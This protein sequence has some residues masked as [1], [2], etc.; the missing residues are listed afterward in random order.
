[1]KVW[2]Y[3]IILLLCG[4]FVTAAAPGWVERLGK[5]E[6]WTVNTS[7]SMEIRQEGDAICFAA[8]NPKGDDFWFYPV[9]TLRPEE[10]A[11]GLVEFS[12]DA[13]TDR[14]ENVKYSFIMAGGKYHKYP[15]P[16]SEWRRVT[17][18]IPAADRKNIRDIKI[19]MNA[20]DAEP[21]KLWV[22]NFSATFVPNVPVADLPA[23][24]ESLALKAAVPSAVFYD[25]EPL[26]FELE[27]RFRKPCRYQV[28][29]WR[30]QEIQAGEFPGNGSAA[31][32]LDKLPCGYYTLKLKSALWNFAE[33]MS[34]AVVPDASKR[35]PNPE[36]FFAVDTAQAV[37][38]IAKKWDERYPGEP[39]DVYS[40]LVRRAGLSVI[41]DRFDWR[42]V[43]AKRGEFKFGES[44]QSAEMLAKRGII[45]C[46]TFGTPPKWSDPVFDFPN[47][48]F[49]LYKTAKKIA[50]KHRGKTFAWEFSNEPDLA[51]K[52]PAWHFAACSKVFYLAVKSADPQTEVVSSA[53][54]IS[55]LQHFAHTALKSGLAEYIDVFNYHVY[56]HLTQYPWI[57][58]RLRSEMAK[59]GVGTMPVYL[60]E[61][62]S[63]VDGDAERK[64]LLHNRYGHSAAQELQVA[65]FIP[66]T[67][68][69]MQELG[70]TRN[71]F[72]IMTPFWEM[73]GKKDWGLFRLD[74]T[75]KPG[76]VALAVLNA[77]LERAKLLGTL[78]LG[79]ESIAGYLY[80]QP[81][82]SQTLVYWSRSEVDNPKYKGENITFRLKQPRGTYQS[83]DL[84]GTPAKVQSAKGVLELT[85]TRYPKYLSGL[86]GLEATTPM[87]PAS[88]PPIKSDKFDRSIVLYPM[89]GDDFVVGPSQ[90]YADQK[91]IP[92]KMTLAIYNFSD[93]PKSGTITMT[94]GNVKGLPEKVAIG[95]FDKVV[96]SLEVSPEIPENDCQAN[97]EFSGNFDGKKITPAVV[98]L[99]QSSAM[100]RDGVG[101][102]LNW[103]DP[104]RWRANSSDGD[105]TTISF[106]EQEKALQLRVVFPKG[107]AGW[108]YPE[109]ILDPSESLAGAI[110]VVFE[111]KAGP[112]IKKGVSYTALMAVLGTEKERGNAFW[113]RFP[114]VSDQWESRTVIFG[115]FDPA[116]V[117]MLRIGMNPK[118]DDFTYYIRNVKVIYGN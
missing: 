80:R 16:G 60:T 87:V 21:C 25:G 79:N 89:L 71:F 40:E 74:Y 69:R 18:K 17:V 72:F 110:G 76:Y 9:F 73:D 23:I 19:G 86:S 41:R 45:S 100:Q 105:K 63:T 27:E 2:S 31:L 58:G 54:S 29:N 32:T 99:V 111:I 83:F 77:E 49:A 109:Y 55:P 59:Y 34:F 68:I 42:R 33:P 65:E 75:V 38:G 118:C 90:A 53:F 78:D 62:G 66:K 102:M 11:A 20:K 67:M 108:C 3:A 46:S 10:H 88:V 48:L 14:P 61:N 117:K 28:M 36:S 113:L 8:R 26:R 70:V 50:E 13:K 37:F 107:K 43:E 96:Y 92:G 104:A 7:G 22:R 57:I 44:E 52:A 115:G 95:A 35:K 112:E 39:F 84:F 101:E 98:P 81:D 4:N 116:E 97:L 64:Y 47:D 103:Q 30:G 106:N 51:A 94:G 24:P 91:K 93:T 82:G 114:T 15:F 56:S 1:M 6:N 12:F 85:A 5:A